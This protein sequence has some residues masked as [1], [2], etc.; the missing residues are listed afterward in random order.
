MKLIRTLPILFLLAMVGACTPSSGSSTLPSLTPADLNTQ[1]TDALK[2]TQPFSGKNFI[3]DGI[4]EVTL[5]STTD[6]DTARF[7]VDN[8]NIAVRFLGI[9]TPESTGKIQ[10]WG[11]AASAFTA[12]ILTTA[13]RIVLINDVDLF[14][15]KDSVGSRFLGFIWYQPATGGDFRL[16]NLEIVEQAF[17]ESLLFNDSPLVPYFESFQAAGQYAQRTKARIY[18]F[19]N[20]PSFDYSDNVYDV[21]IRFVRKAFGSTIPL[22]DKEGRVI[23]DENDESKEHLKALKELKK[24]FKHTP[25]NF[26]N[27]NNFDINQRLILIYF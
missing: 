1:Y 23:L 27:K 11:N 10:P 3:E 7:N 26:I 24:E 6:G 21:S 20:D 12:N 18:G 14:G 5:R 9:N 19:R 22:E 16:L 17:S 4:G 13:N 15:Q 25:A 8:V 2:L